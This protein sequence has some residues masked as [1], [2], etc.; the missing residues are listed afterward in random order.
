MYQSW[1]NAQW[2]CKSENEMTKH[3]IKTKEEITIQLKLL[4]IRDMGIAEKMKA[5]SLSRLEI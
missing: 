1:K 2:L 5:T 3:A 4:R